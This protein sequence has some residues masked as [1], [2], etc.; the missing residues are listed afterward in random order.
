MRKRTFQNLTAYRGGAELQAWAARQLEKLVA[1][2]ASAKP[3][4]LEIPADQYATVKHAKGAG[5][6]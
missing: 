3:E 1:P 6:A 4:Q 2:S 5:Q